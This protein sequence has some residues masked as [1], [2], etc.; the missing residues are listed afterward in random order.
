VVQHID[1]TEPAGRAEGGA[2]ARAHHEPGRCV[3]AG[4]RHDRSGP[5]WGGDAPFAFHTVNH[6]C[7]VLLHRRARRLTAENG[8]FRPGQRTKPR[9]WRRMQRSG[10]LVS[11]ELSSPD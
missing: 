3:G 1:A 10:R 7:T 8:G 5:T 11:V 4:L 6:F 9:R 2:A